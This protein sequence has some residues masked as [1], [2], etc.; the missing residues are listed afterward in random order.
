MRQLEVIFHQHMN[1]TNVSGYQVALS[2]PSN[3]TDDI[4]DKQF[5]LEEEGKKAAYILKD[6][7]V[8]AV[9]GYRD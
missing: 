3:V 9:V 7:N 8:V 4:L 5:Y 2:L 1:G 6:G